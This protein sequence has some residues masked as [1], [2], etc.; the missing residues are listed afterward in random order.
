MDFEKQKKPEWAERPSTERIESDKLTKL[1]RDT[2]RSLLNHQKRYGEPLNLVDYD[3]KTGKPRDMWTNLFSEI[4]RIDRRLESFRNI[5]YTIEFEKL[6]SNK[7]ELYLKLR[8][9]NEKTRKELE[10]EGL[11]SLNPEDIFK[12]PDLENMPQ[13]ELE[14]VLEEED[15]QEALID[16][17]NGQYNP[18]SGEKIPNKI[19]DPGG[20]GAAVLGQTEYYTRDRHAYQ[21]AARLQLE[22]DVFV[23][24]SD[25]NGVEYLRRVKE[26]IG[27]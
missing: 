26:R 9:G 11:A 23:N 8:S 20:Y 15:Y 12:D 27:E 14:K 1:E 16:I 19:K 6:P 3:P 13:Q 24:D 4:D 18:V 5:A 22:Y 17:Q 2:L 21:E 25:H 10:K 7:K